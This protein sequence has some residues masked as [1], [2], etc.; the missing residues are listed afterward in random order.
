[1][2][3]AYIVS[4]AHYG[5][6]IMSLA[7]VEKT[8]VLGGETALRR[9][10]GLHV[11]DDL[12]AELDTQPE[13]AHG[14]YEH[15]KFTSDRFIKMGQ[16][17]GERN[18]VTV[19]LKESILR[20]GLIN[21]IDTVRL[22]DET[23]A[24][25]IAFVNRVWKTE[26][27]VDDFTESKQEDGFYYL[28]VAGH[29]RHEAIC[30]LEEEGLM[31]TR[32]IMAK[33]HEV[34]SPEQIIMIQLDE[35]LH[36]QPSRERSA[37]AIVE[38][39][40]F[41]TEQGR[42]STQKEFLAK[43]PH[44]AG[45]QFTEALHFSELHP[46]IRDFILTGDM[47]VS[48]GVEIGK[49]EKYIIR[50]KL[51]QVALKTIDELD[52]SD[53]AT[54]T[55]FVDHEVM[56]MTTHIAKHGLPPSRANRYLAGQRK[57]FAPLLAQTDEARAAAEEDTLL[58]LDF[59]TPSQMLREDLRAVQKARELSLREIGTDPGDK[60]RRLLSL[61]QSDPFIPPEFIEKAVRDLESTTRRAAIMLGSTASQG[62]MM[63]EA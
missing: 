34:A 17:R 57:R 20:Q 42:W 1:M 21:P 12:Q 45:S 48:T 28:I 41:G 63:F 8:P 47:A 29:S 10:A 7:E 51:A 59:I 26:T 18:P 53:Q 62:T 13:R 25:Y 37:I 27:V 55:E 56:M 2:S 5:H 52:P 33:V 50:A 49:M 61:Q 14:E 39:Y 31:E 4:L 22:T 46:H 11:V 30:E 35:N 3:L 16:V 24:E 44:I 38:M 54:L 40:Q 43:N 15:I 32:P 9:K 23:L 36:S 19:S 6:Y 60:A 58:G